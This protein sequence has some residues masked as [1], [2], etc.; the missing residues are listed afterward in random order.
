MCEHPRPIK[1]RTDNETEFN[2]FEFQEMMHSYGT[3]VLPTTVKNPATNAIV[4]R[5]RLWMA[6]VL[7]MKTF[8]GVNW[9][10]EVDCTLQTVAWIFHTMVPSTV[11]RSP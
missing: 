1:V 7:R 4:E 8:E 10:F 2:G 3:K 5:L 6:D 11:P 9:K